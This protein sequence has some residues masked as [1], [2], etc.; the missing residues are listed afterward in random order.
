MMAASHKKAEHRNIRLRVGDTTI[1][2]KLKDGP[3]ARDFI[4]MLPLTLTMNDLYRREKFAPLPRPIS[5]DG[6][7]THIRCR[8]Y[9]LLATRAQYRHLL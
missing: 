8:G 9:C 1:T 2:A 7:H 6:K 5:T 4:S 3:T